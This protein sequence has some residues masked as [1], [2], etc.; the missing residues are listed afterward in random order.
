MAYRDSNILQ[1][2][3]VSNKVLYDNRS[4]IGNNP[5]M[6]DISQNFLQCFVNVLTKIEK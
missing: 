5:Q 2:R 6:M 3:S 1:R 4:T